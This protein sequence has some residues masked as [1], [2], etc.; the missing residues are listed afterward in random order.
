[1]S[2]IKFLDDVGIESDS[3]LTMASSLGSEYLTIDN[4][5]S[6]G[7]TSSFL[8]LGNASVDTSLTIERNNGEAYVFLSVGQL[9][10]Y[11]DGEVPSMLQ[12]FSTTPQTLIFGRLT[13][14]VAAGQTSGSSIEFREAA[15]SGTNFVR[16][17]AADSITASQD[18]T[19]PTNYPSSNGQVLS[20]TT[21]GVMSWS[22]GGTG[23]T[24]IANTNLT[25]DA[26]RT[27]SLGT[28]SLDI[29]SGSGNVLDLTS[30]NVQIY[31]ALYLRT[32]STTTAPE[33]RFSEG[34]GND[35]I[36]L[37]APDTL[38][39]GTV[40]TL[41]ATDGTAG[42]VLQTDGS[43]G[44]SFATG[45]TGGNSSFSLISAGG[46]VTINTTSD[47]NARII[48]L[49]GGLGVNYFN[50]TTFMANGS[51]SFISLGTPGTSTTLGVPYNTN[52][53]AFVSPKSGKITMTGT[54]EFPSQSETQN[55]QCFFYIFRYPSSLVTAMANGTYVASTQMT[56]VGSA[57]VTV[58]SASQNIIPM[59]FT[60]GGNITANSGEYFFAAFAYRGTVSGSRYFTINYN[61]FTE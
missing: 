39:A 23:D 42:Q 55:N 48:V 37:K 50:W 18:Y 10:F 24:N 43:G 60:V 4:N 14:A 26:N 8:R 9:T 36:G 51:P 22:T 54:V 38:S 53:A 13:V 41:P 25:L 35:Y 45:G 30:S 5:N 33:M 20:S 57:S 12:F 2:N 58:P 49:G 11:V 44:L 1:M 6:T 3:T 47:A 56:L 40:F 31:N 46:R 59:S 29:N 17:K 15:T 7:S 19:L 34:T 61:L 16:L 52:N 21:A 27:T 32:D 28:F